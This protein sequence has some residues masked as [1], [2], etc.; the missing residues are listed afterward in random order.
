MPQQQVPSNQVEKN[1]P[2]RLTQMTEK[3]PYALPHHIFYN[4]STASKV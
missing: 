1:M 3:K 4:P 2:K